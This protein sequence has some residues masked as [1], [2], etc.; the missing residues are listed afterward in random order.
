MTKDVIAL[1]PTMPDIRT[2]LAGLY[3]GGPDVRVDS[4][5]DGAVVQLRAPGGHPL[6][7]VEAPIFVQVPGE[8][9]RLLGT[10]IG[11]AGPFWWTETRSTTAVPDAESLARSFAGR[12]VSVLGGTT[13]PP[14]P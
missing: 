4:A 9:S 6:I 8:A 1:T 3:A 13:W 7:S 11:D 12:L 2:L 10:A 5:G 14:A